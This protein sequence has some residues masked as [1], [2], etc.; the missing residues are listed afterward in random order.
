MSGIIEKYLTMIR[1]AT[2]RPGIYAYRGQKNSQWALHSAATRRLINEYGSQVLGYPDFCAIYLKYHRNRLI[3]PARARGFDG[4]HGRKISDLQLFAKLQHLG[5]ATGLLDFTWSPLVALW[6]ASQASAH[7]GQLFVVDIAKTVHVALVQSDEEE[8]KAEI[9][10]SGE[11]HSL[12]RLWY[13]EPSLSGDVMSRVLRQR[14]LF[15]IGRP[16]VPE[17]DDEIV[18]KISIAQQDKAALLEDLKLLDITQSS[19][20]QDIYGFS[21][22]ESVSS[23]LPQQITE[24]KDYFLRGNLFYQRGEYLKAIDAYSKSIELAPDICE[25][26]FLRG[27]AKAQIKH[28][29]EALK[30]YDKAVFHKGRPFL[31]VARGAMALNHNPLLFMIYCNRGNAKAELKDYE[32][33]LRDYGETIQL[34][35]DYSQSFFNRANTYADL[36]RFEEAVDDYDQAIQLGSRHAHFNKANA[37]VLLGRFDEALQCYEESEKHGTKVSSVNRENLEII[38]NKI[39]GQTYKIYLEEAKLSGVRQIVSIRIDNYHGEI[40]QY[41]FVGSVGNTGNFGGGIFP[42]GEGF[43]GKPGFAVKV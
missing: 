19:L 28:Y 25:T 11:N 13:W 39:L 20:F 18:G 12:P 36:S 9:V 32:G 4:E 17:E 21:E 24:P 33:A 31:S 42:G 5:A 30:D 15:I 26:Y 23:P 16:L 2:S 38:I 35:S 6:F 29:K 34:N 8:Q 22:A 7:D 40:R 10:F 43:P 27:N 41:L 1:E 14:S 37:L 3:E